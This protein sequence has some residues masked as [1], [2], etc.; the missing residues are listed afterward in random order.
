MIVLGQLLRQHIKK[1]QNEC[2][3]FTDR[4]AVML[5]SFGLGIPV[6]DVCLYQNREISSTELTSICG[7]MR[8]RVLGE[9]TAKIIGKKEFWNS[10]FYVDG[11]VLDP[12]P[13]TEILIETV[14]NNSTNCK[15]ILDLGTGSGCIAISLDLELKKVKVMGSDISSEA[16]HIA[17]KNSKSNKASVSFVRSDWFE[18][19]SKKYDI[20][21]SNPPYIKDNELITLPQAV[22]NYD[23]WTALAGGEDGLKCYR[24]IASSISLFLNEGGVGIFE[25]GFG[26]KNSVI[27]IFS[28]YGLSCFD[29]KQDLRGLDRVLCVKKDA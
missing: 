19:I 23:P 26:Q 18:S 2:S 10:S 16:L 20:I 5:L 15:T 8:R 25:I 29:V 1:I 6:T 24:K 17:R 9:P 27:K 3:D 4:E 7:L 13:E 12:R 22:R 11:T 14:L 28:S 21:V